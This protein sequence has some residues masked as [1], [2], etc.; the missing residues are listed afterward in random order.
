LLF[1]VILLFRLINND[2]IITELFKAAGYTYGPLLGLFAFGLFTSLKIREKVY[3]EN[4]KVAMPVVV[5]SLITLVGSAAGIV[6]NI[7]LS[8]FSI[9]V[10]A[11]F[12]SKWVR[13]TLFMENGR[14][15]LPALMLV[16][17]AAPIISM[18]VDY[19]SA[20]LLRGF[21]F[22][23]LILAFNGLL[24]F[25]GLVALSDFGDFVPAPEEEA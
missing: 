18:V 12:L 7:Y 25:L 19:Y 23:F 11:S 4:V 6:D 3:F 21:K 14:V 9:I 10:S 17:I 8:I 13:A 16:C 20:Y 2:A 5:F 15:V 24:T 1:L 22:G